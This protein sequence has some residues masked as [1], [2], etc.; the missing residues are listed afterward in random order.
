MSFN[1][2]GRAMNTDL[3][4]WIQMSLVA[5]PDSIEFLENWDCI[6]GIGSVPATDPDG[7]PIT[8]T[9]DI[10]C[11]G[12]VT[13]SHACMTPNAPLTLTFPYGCGKILFTT[14][15][16]VGEMGGPHPELL[17]QEK[18]LVYMILEIGLCTDPV[19]I[20]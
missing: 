7:T 6:A 8:V 10:Y 9:P 2:T 16:T 20:I 14:Y 11:D 4:Q 19:I 12:P 13:R 5:N 3:R 18:I 15:H 17:M 1:T